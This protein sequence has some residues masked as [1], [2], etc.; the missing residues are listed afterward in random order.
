MGETQEQLNCNSRNSTLLSCNK[1]DVVSQTTGQSNRKRQRGDQPRHKGRSEN[2]CCLNKLR[3]AMIYV[4]TLKQQQ[5]NV[6]IY[7]SEACNAT[8][9]N[10]P[11]PYLLPV[12]LVI[13]E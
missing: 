6:L 8:N 12:S 13:P 1:P 11:A 3:R 2:W 10:K 4:A 9:C 7:L 5:R